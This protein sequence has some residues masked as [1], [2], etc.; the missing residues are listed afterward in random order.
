MT[1]YKPYSP[2]W[3]RQRYLKEALLK[4]LD[5]GVDNNAIYTDILDILQERSESAYAE[6]E[7][8][9]ELESMLQSK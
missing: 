3:H 7:R 8:V 4:Y 9:T 1:H 5:D 2:E 6:Y